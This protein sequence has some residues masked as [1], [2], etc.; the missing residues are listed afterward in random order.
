MVLMR[1]VVPLLSLLLFACVVVASNV[2]LVLRRAASVETVFWSACNKTNGRPPADTQA[3]SLPADDVQWNE[4][5][6][7]RATLSCR[8]PAF[9][10]LSPSSFAASS[11]QLSIGN[12][13]KLESKH[14]PQPPLLASYRWNLA[15]NF[16]LGPMEQTEL[17]QR[18]SR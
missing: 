2:R 12:V 10:S 17:I 16:D 9:P 4:E 18:S 6:R 3:A 13:I 15:T 11:L 5:R 14:L 8:T 1:F 7:Q